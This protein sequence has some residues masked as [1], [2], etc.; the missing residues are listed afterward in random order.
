MRISSIRLR[1]FKRFSD[2]EISEIPEAAKLVV[3]VGPN[4]CG[5]SSLFDAMLHW[6]RT[7]VGLGWV[8]DFSYLRKNEE[9]GFKPDETV[10]VVVH[11]EQELKRGALYM[12][13]AYRNDPDFSV[14]GI[15]RP[16]NPS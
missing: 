3:V 10:A 11:S 15:S 16:Q 6:Y 7:S 8:G 5:K 13:T 9:E 14:D 4:G 1:N 12:R 2:L